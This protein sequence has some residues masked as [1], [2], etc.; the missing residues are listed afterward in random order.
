MPAQNFTQG[1]Y[2]KFGQKVFYLSLLRDAIIFIVGIIV[3][4]GLSGFLGFTSQI[5]SGIFLGGT[6]LLL[7]YAVA[8]ILIAKYQ[9]ACRKFMLD[10]F[11]VHIRNGIINTSEMSI[12]YRQIQDVNIEESYVQRAFGVVTLS[13]L[14]AG[15]EDGRFSKTGEAGVPEEEADAL[16][17]VIEHDYAVELQKI[18]MQH[19]SIQEVVTVGQAVANGQVGTDGPTRV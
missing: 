13:V 6:I 8:A 9:Y 10:E 11:A 4:I 16:F 17:P 12:P 15:H 19:S 18:L 1:V 7:L 2:Y 3:V 5:G 14:T